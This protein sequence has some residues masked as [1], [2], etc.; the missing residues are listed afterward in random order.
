MKIAYTLILIVC[1]SS[2]EHSSAPKTQAPQEKLLAQDK[3]DQD[4]ITQDKA[5]ILK[6]MKEQQIAWSKNDLEGFMQGYVN[7]DSLK[8]YGKSGLTKGWQQTLDNYKKGYPT[9]E[10]SGTLTFTINDISNIETN[11]YW[12]M[13]EYFLSREIADAK[14]VFMVIFKNIDGS[15]K[16]VADMSCG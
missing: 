3:I 16:I 6:V 1:L 11:S 15:W 7:S 2:C 8:F 5:A 14:G 9:K 10:Q 4:K 12:V 13:G